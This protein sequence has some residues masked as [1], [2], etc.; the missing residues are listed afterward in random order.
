MFYWF[1]AGNTLTNYP[2]YI[3]INRIVKFVNPH[4]RVYSIDN[5]LKEFICLQ[6]VIFLDG[7]R[8]ETLYIKFVHMYIVKADKLDHLI[9]IL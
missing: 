3:H 8:V 5:Q 7:E 2:I 1:G 9:D 6:L 4:E